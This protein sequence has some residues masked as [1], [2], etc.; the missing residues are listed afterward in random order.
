MEKI[1]FRYHK[2]A[3]VRKIKATTDKIKVYI[4]FQYLHSV[5]RVFSRD[6]TPTIIVVEF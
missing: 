1:V 5:S 4:E 3:H 6:F 2:V